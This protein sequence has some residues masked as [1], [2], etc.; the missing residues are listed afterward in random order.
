MALDAGQLHA[1]VGVSLNTYFT[2]N[3]K[4]SGRSR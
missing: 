2:T 3:L 1:L 4:N